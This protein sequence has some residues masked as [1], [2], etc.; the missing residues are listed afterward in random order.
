MDQLRTIDAD[1]VGV[2]MTVDA[3][4]GQGRRILAAGLAALV[5]GGAGAASAAPTKPKAAT[6]RVAVVVPSGAS[7]IQSGLVANGAEVAASQINA[8]GGVLGAFTIKLTRTPMRSSTRPAAVVR[9]LVASRTNVV[10]LPCNDD[11]QADLA[12][13]ASSRGI[14]VLAPCNTFSGDIP[15]LVWAVGPPPSE[16]AAQLVS[17]IASQR[18]GTLPTAFLL[19]SSATSSY[20]STM[21]SA[22]R[23][24]ASKNKMKLVGQGTVKRD[25]ADAAAVAAAIRKSGAETVLSTVGAPFATTVIDR[26]RKAGYTKQIYLT[27]AMDA[28][29]ARK[30][31]GAALHESYFVTYGFARPTARPFLRDYRARFR[32]A[33]PGSFPGLGYETVRVLEAALKQSRSVVPGKID[34]ALGRGFSLTGVALGD[35]IYTGNGVRRPVRDVGIAGI[36]NGRYMPLLSGRPASSTIPQ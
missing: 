13:A 30:G 16:Q 28:T 12:K 22:L 27:D 32:F 29:V 34:G 19:S 21:A 26:L 1:H 25:A 14:L 15:P 2:L 10:I 7:G 31:Y 11:R 6:L 36:L 3:H 23:A 4:R 24:A 35:T 20:E 9:G 18:A 17:Y 8:K 33:P 5:M